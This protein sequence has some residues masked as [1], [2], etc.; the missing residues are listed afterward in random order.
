MSDEQ[1]PLID[2]REFGRRAKAA[3][4]LAGYDSVKDAVFALQ[5]RMGV[6]ISPRQMYAIERGDH[7]PSVD[8]FLAIIWGYRPPGFT[9]FFSTAFR[10]DI[11]RVSIESM[12]DQLRVFRQDQADR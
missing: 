4:I 11:L 1:A 7:M 10:E 3:R 2:T 9:A 12:D 5:D 8:Q 6:A